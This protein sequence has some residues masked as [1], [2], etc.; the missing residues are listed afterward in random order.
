VKSLAQKFKATLIYGL[1]IFNDEPE[2]YSGD[3][4]EDNP[5]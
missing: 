2:N 4:T 1:I 5:T 3:N